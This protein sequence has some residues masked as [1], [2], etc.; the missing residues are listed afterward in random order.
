MVP[1]KASSAKGRGT[2]LRDVTAEDRGATVTC[3]CTLK[4]FLGIKVILL[5]ALVVAHLTYNSLIPCELS[6]KMGFGKRER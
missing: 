4:E 6:V 2:G 5:P 1:S 3:P